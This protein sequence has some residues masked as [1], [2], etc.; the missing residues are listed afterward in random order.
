MR[1]VFI[2]SLLLL[3]WVELKAFAFLSTEIGWLLTF[4]GVFFTAIIGIGFLKNQGLS[5]LNRVRSDL[6]RGHSPVVPIADSISLVVGGGLMLIPGY[7]TDGVGI[8]LFIPGF[9]T[10]AGMYLLGWLAK[11]PGLTGFV[12]FSESTSAQESSNRGQTGLN[13][14]PSH[15]NNFDDVIEGEFE[16]RPDAESYTDHK[17]GTTKVID[18]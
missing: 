15:R 12:N 5:L 10:T 8:L 17:K 4:F 14:R 13:E 9:R 18:K 3:G 1:L 16:E 6:T 2:I 7:V 11:R